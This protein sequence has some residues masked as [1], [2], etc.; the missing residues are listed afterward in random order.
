MIVVLDN[1]RSAHNVGS[2]FRTA[3][4]FGIEK[5]YLCGV[6]PGPRDR[7]G[8]PNTKVTKV[9]LGAEQTVPF[10]HVTDAPSGIDILKRQN[11]FV[12]ALEQDARAQTPERVIAS[13]QH[14]ERVAIVLGNEVEGLPP[15]VLD[16]VDIIMEIP[17]RGAK[18]SLNVSVAFGIAAY[19]LR[20]TVLS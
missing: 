15:V 19:V 3:D 2:I 7:F 1:I 20:M 6:T 18:E 12:I 13:V 14:E 5:I 4:A 17:M 9:S 16:A 8:R 10:E 11:Y